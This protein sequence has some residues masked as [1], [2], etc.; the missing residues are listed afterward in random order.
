VRIW[1]Q[2][3]VELDALPAYVESL[4]A[5]VRAVASPGVVVD[6]HGLARGTYTPHRTAADLAGDPS[7]VNAG[8]AQVVENIRRA[9]REGYDAAAITIVQ[10]IGLREARAAVGIPVASYGEA[11]MHLACM[12]GERFGVVAF[13]PAIA[14]IVA[15]E[16]ARLGLASRAAP[17]EVVDTDYGGV[18]EAFDRPDRLI[19]AFANAARRAIAR[20]AESIIPGQTIMAEILWQQGVRR[21]DETPVIDALGVT[22]ATAELLVRMRRA[23]D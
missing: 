13:D 17:V 6:L 22:I 1:H 7:L 20:G 5:H 9:E 16:I 10:N 14:E 8:L 12:V 23:A 18:V 21:I 2:G 3:F 15:R 19:D 11:A 4:H